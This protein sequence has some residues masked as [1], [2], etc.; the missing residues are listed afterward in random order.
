L[1]SGLTHNLVIRVP[2]MGKACC[3]TLAVVLAGI[4]FVHGSEPERR[5]AV[6]TKYCNA[7][8]GN[9][10]YAQYSAANN[11]VYRVAIPDTASAPF[12]A[13]IQIVSPASLGWAGI[14]WGGSMANNPL[15]VAWGN[16]DGAVV[17]S[18]WTTYALPSPWLA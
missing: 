10:C 1:V 16:G 6:T 12:D 5:Q 8:F 14:A 18:R 2:I 9:V 11:V 17:S 13:L 4:S 7:E 3:A 15:T